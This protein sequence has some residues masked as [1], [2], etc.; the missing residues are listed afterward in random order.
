MEVRVNSSDW[1]ELEAVDQA[2]V[3]QAIQKHFASAQIVPDPAAP[4]AKIASVVKDGGIFSGPCKLACDA[5]EAAAVAACASLP[6]PA[7]AICIVA[8]HA[9][10][11]ACRNAC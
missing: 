5:A 4:K 1:K 9:A 8:A 11:E 10:G 3:R 6:G 7:A 2:K